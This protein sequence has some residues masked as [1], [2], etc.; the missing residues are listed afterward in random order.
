MRTFASA[1]LVTLSLHQG[2]AQP[3][4]KV[5]PKDGL[6]YTFLPAGTFV[7]GCSPGDGQC[8]DDEKPAHR[9][10]ITKGFWIGQTT[11]TIGAWKQYAKATGKSLLPEKDSY[12]YPLN[13]SLG[14]DRQPVVLVTWTEA[15]AYCTWSGMR[16]PTE[17]EWEYAA[18]GNVE[19]ARYGKLDDIAWYA[20]NTGRQRIDSTAL[21]VADPGKFVQRLTENGA[22]PQPVGQKQ[23]NAFGLYDMLGNVWQWT[24]DWYG[25]EYYQ[26]SEERDPAGPQ[27][28]TERPL[29][30]GAWMNDPKRV[31]VSSRISHEPDTR[32]NASGFRCAAFEFQDA[33]GIRS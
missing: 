6:I 7:M 13:T 11:V 20:D 1:I 10:A 16:L 30:G 9:V 8:N 15:A 4:S 12:G 25:K 22:T 28:G 31:R 27:M 26:V 18:R 3:N 24:A 29:R 33:P 14:D 5:N 32:H 23:P 21:R 19:R 17:A 2:W